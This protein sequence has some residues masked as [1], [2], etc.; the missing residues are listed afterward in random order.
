MP[1]AP[2]GDPSTIVSF[3]GD[4]AGVLSTN[5]YPNDFI[6]N[7]LVFDYRGSGSFQLS[8]S[9]GALSFAGT[10]PAISVEGNG[11]R[12]REQS[13]Q[14]ALDGR[15]HHQRRWLG[16]FGSSCI[17][18]RQRRRG[19]DRSRWFHRAWTASD[20]GWRLQFYRRSAD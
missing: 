12:S 1:P 15:P 3:T 14:A 4:R 9:K 13:H 6:L 5:D 20:F 17:L 2:G 16:R 7:R 18:L 19:R 10:S 11:K 8:S